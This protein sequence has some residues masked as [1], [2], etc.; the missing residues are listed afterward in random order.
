[1]HTPRNEQID[2]CLKARGNGQFIQGTTK[3]KEAFKY[4]Q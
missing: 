1:M 4:L 3:H 2:L